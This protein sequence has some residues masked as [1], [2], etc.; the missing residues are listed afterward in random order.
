MK[1][2]SLVWLLL[3]V[4][5]SLTLAWSVIALQSRRECNAINDNRATIRAIFVQFEKSAEEDAKAS[6]TPL[7]QAQIKARQRFFRMVSEQ[8]TPL[9]C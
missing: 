5:A 7:T 8:L 3:A 2:K 4:A 1:H 9:D 6:G